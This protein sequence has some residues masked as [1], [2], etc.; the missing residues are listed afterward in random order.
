MY[1]SKTLKYAYGNFSRLALA[2]QTFLVD[3]LEKMF[4]FNIKK[5]NLP[6]HACRYFY[7]RR[8]NLS[9]SEI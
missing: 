7:G 9:N 6:M 5:I 4:F 8:V 3:F 2:S 1:I